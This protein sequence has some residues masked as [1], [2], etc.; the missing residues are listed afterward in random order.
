MQKLSFSNVFTETLQKLGLRLC[1][2]ITNHDN[3]S[4]FGKFGDEF[5]QYI[6]II[7]SKCSN[8]YFCASEEEIDQIFLNNK[9][10]TNIYVLNNII[11]LSNFEKPMTLIL[12]P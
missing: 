3:F 5:Y 6:R 11:D 1:F 9:I 12:K 2:N 7:I 10:Y 8:S 4:T